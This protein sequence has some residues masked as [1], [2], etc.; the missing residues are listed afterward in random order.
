MWRI[1][2]LEE[3][4]A[5]GFA[6]YFRGSWS[7]LPIAM[8]SSDCQVVAGTGRKRR[9]LASGLGS[10]DPENPRAPLGKRPFT[11]LVVLTFAKVL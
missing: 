4:Q 3:Q 7:R 10:F 1:L 8:C 2:R 9:F 5:L 11:P 6:E